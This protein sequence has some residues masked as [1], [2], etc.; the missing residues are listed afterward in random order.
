MTATEAAKQIAL[1]EEIN[2]AQATQITALTEELRLMRNALYGRRRETINPGQLHLFEAQVD[3]TE[4]PEAPA[5]PARRKPRKGHGRAPFPAHLPRETIEIDVPEADRCCPEC[6]DAMQPFGEESSERGHIVPARIVVRRYI[7][8]RY[9]CKAGHAVLTAPMPPGVV[10]GGKYEASVYSHIAVTK[11]G[12]HTPLNR[13]Q[14]IFKRHGFHLPRQ[15]MWEMLVRLDELVAQPVLRQMRSELLSEDVLHADETPVTFRLEDGKGR[16]TGY[17]W[18][19]RNLRDRGDS[20]VL[21]EFKTSRARAGPTDFL[22]RWRG[23]LLADGYSGYDEVVATNGIVRAGCWVHVRRKFRDALDA[24]TEAAAVVLRPIQRLFWI[25]RAIKKRSK[26]EQMSWADLVALR[27]RVRQQHSVRV[28]AQIHDA[29]R[30]LSSRRATLPK[31]ALGKALTYLCNQAEALAA[32]VN[33]ARLPIHNNGAERDLRHVAMGRRNWLVFASERG[34]E[35][36]SR[37]YSLL[38][39]C[40]EAGVEPEAYL[41]DVLHRVAT[42]P[43]SDIASLTPWGWRAAQQTSP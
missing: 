16:K 23:T 18:G 42:T 35:V 40:K 21:I 39:S 19:W 37:L 34:G 2:A 1:L 4:T 25:E 7:R 10:D 22:G 15:S 24:G 17:I 30:E 29:G 27:N 9:S 13:L 43:A 32:S 38:L 26:A 41:E 11:Y 14:S 20:K 8:K 33:D 28:L 5:T 3:A 36:A 12:D 31:S 6:G